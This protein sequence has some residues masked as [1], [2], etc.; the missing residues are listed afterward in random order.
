VPSAA[1]AAAGTY[2]YRQ[3]GTSSVGSVPSEGTLRVDRASPDGRQVFHRALDPSAPP[4]DLQ[5]LFASGG[6]FLE[7]T[8]TRISS[9]GQ[10]TTFTCTFDPPVPAPP[11]PPA[12]GKAFNGAGDCGSFNAQI[13][14]TISGTRSAAVDG[15]QRILYVINFTIVTHGQIESQ[16]NETDWFSP[17]LR[18]QVH[19]ESHA[20]GT[21]GLISFKSDVTSDLESGHPA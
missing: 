21:Y 20:Q 9:A 1:P 12:V 2:R 7:K 8:V 15:V 13:N 17:D 5:L 14:G 19:T 10:T 4:N 11:W 6:M 18:L 3:T 16:Q